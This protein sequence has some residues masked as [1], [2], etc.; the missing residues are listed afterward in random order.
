MTFVVSIHSHHPSHS[1]LILFHQTVNVNSDEEW[2]DR[3]NTAGIIL[4]LCLLLL[5]VVV[6]VVVVVHIDSNAPFV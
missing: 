3:I 4:T 2:F 5:L 6:V 1:D